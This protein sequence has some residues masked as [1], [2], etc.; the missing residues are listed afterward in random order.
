MPVCTNCGKRFSGFSFG[1]TVATECRDCRKARAQADA[2]V[3]PLAEGKPRETLLP[4]VTIGIIGLNTLVYLAMGL[5]GASWTD[6]TIQQA[7][8]WGAD[9][10]PLTLSGEWWRLFTSTF[11][12]YGIVHIALNMWCLFNLGR[13]LESLMGRKAFGVMYC[14][15]G[16]AASLV[17]VAW[18]PWRVAA[19]A[20]GAIFGVAGALLSYLALKRVA[21]GRALV[22]TNLKSLITFIIYNLVWSAAGPVDGAAHVGGLVAGMILGAVIPPMPVSTAMKEDFA[23]QPLGIDEPLGSRENRIAWTTAA[24]SILVLILA[25]A[26]VCRVNSSA[27]EYG[28]AVKLIE[29]GHA[30]EAVTELARDTPSGRGTVSQQLLLGQMLLEREQPSAA[31]P[32]LE[33]ALELEPGRVMIEHNLAVAYLG[34][35]RPVEAEEHIHRV[36]DSETADPAAPLFIRGVAEGENSN[37]VPAINDLREVVKVYPDWPPAKQALALFESEQRESGKSRVRPDLGDPPQ[38][39]LAIP[40][41]NLVMKS[42]AW[43]FIP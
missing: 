14:A 37:F 2:S 20:S 32:P 43:P 26:W 11:V 13:S 10:G 3:V 9:Y 33:R 19:G 7:V 35:G 23:A 5:S 15:S 27:E 36:F 31:I 17:S 42:G 30:D 4:V 38:T 29:A 8:R 18:N 21:P 6:P 12:H 34:A 28:R 25:G 1:S 16:L 40:Y 24:C 39:P 22:R 41:S